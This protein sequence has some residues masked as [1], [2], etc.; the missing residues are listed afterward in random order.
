MASTT[1]IPVAT[2]GND[3]EIAQSVSEK[4]LPEFEVVHCSLDIQTALAELPA[5]CAGDLT[6]LPASGLGTN[7]GVAEPSERKVPEAIFFGGGFSDDE[8]EALVGAVREATA[9]GAGGA[10]KPVQFIKV[11]RRD[12]LAA[13]S[14]G[15]NPE[16]IARIYKRKMAAA[17]AAAA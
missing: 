13:G 17:L 12:V 2:Y 3:P 14:F 8:Y 7:Q 1:P 11:Q 16:V 10:G 15:P 6:K 5:L 9:G 4:L